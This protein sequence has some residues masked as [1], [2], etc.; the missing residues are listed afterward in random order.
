MLNLLKK[1]VSAAEHK[2]LE[3]DEQYHSLVVAAADENEGDPESAMQIM[4]AAGKSIDDLESDVVMLLKR[5]EWAKT[6]HVE[7]Q[8]A[9]E[10]KTAEQKISKLAEKRQKLVDPI[11]AEMAELR[12]IVDAHRQIQI[13]ANSARRQLRETVPAFVKRKKE[14]LM[15]LVREKIVRHKNAI[16]NRGATED[17]LG[18][19]AAK[20][21][22]YFRYASDRELAEQSV[23]AHRKRLEERRR[24]EREAEQDVKKA[25]DARD[26]VIE[27]LILNT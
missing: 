23:K 2:Q 13:N 18:I 7:E 8:H 24:Q 14:E 10:V 5:R 15:V 9:A 27:P 25:S 16:A 20:L 19:E 12:S 11:V 6:I 3:T 22:G 4:E 21:T 26:A 17:S 1:L